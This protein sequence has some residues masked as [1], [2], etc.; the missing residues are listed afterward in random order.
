MNTTTKTLSVAIAMFAI[1]GM[2]GVFNNQAFANPKDSS[3]DKIQGKLLYK[4]NMIATPQEWAADDDLCPNNGHRIFF[5]QVDKGNTIGT[6]QWNLNNETSAGLIDIYD[7]DGTTDGTAGIEIDEGLEFAVYVRVHGQNTDR[8]D[9]VCTDQI[10]SDNEDDLCL[11]DTVNMLHKS[12][13]F[14]KI[15]TN[16]YDGEYEQVLW[17]LEN[18][19]GFKNAEVRLYSIP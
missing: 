17:T 7:C 12:K 11:I 4:F 2:M 5:P 18:G 8:L 10:V 14:T 16:L 3:G 15:M 19:N 13:S 6:L 9:L 1:V